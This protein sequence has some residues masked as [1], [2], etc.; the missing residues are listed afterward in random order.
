M[1]VTMPGRSRRD[2]VRYKEHARD[3]V[4]ARLA[5]FNREYGFAIGRIAIRNQK[6]RWGS[7]SKKGNLNFSYRLILLPREVADYIIVHELCHL[8]QFNHS[9]RFWALVALSC[10]DYRALRARL[11]S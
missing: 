10:P 4:R 11:R 9:P 3:L 1:M 6:S 7:C 2:Y 5:H 8:G